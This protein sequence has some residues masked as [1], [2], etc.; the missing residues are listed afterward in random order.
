ME[1]VSDEEGR[2]EEKGV[3][4]GV[5][6]EDPPVPCFLHV[7]REEEEEEEE[8]DTVRLYVRL[9]TLKSCHITYSRFLKDKTK[10]KKNHQTNRI[11][12]S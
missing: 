5:R 7:L 9:V 6:V 3:D 4:G 10:R 2:D 8:E 11:P 1:E 12:P